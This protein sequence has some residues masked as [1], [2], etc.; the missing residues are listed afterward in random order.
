MKTVLIISYYWPPAGGPGVQR[1]LKFARYLHELGWKVVVLTVKDGVYPARDDSLLEEIPSEVKVF[2]SFSPEPEM[3]LKKLA[4]SDP[5]PSPVGVLA[6]KPSS[7]HKRIIHHIRLNYF[8]PDAK[9][10]WRYNSRRIAERLVQLYKPDIVF[11]TSPPPTTHLIAYD[12]KKRFPVRWVADFRDPWSR[13]HYYRGKRSAWAEKWDQRLERKVLRGCDRIVCVSRAFADLLVESYPEKTTIIPNGYDAGDFVSRYR[14]TERFNI[15]YIGGL[16]SN[17]WY[18]SLFKAIVRLLREGRLSAPEVC[19][20][21]AG[22]IAP[23]ILAE[24]RYIFADYPGVLQIKEYVPHKQATAMMQ[25]ADLL[26]LFMEKV[27]RYQGHLPGKLFEYLAALRPVLGC[28]P[29]DGEAAG[30]LRE[31]QAGGVYEQ[32]EK[33]ADFI[34]TVFQAWKKGEP[35]AVKEQDIVRFERKNLTRRLASVFEE[36][37]KH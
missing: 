35:P 28:G 34:M 25:Q 13:I 30:L 1:P 16:N 6:E 8:I 24:L 4:S 9:V 12:I 17:R 33:M 32:P 15:L 27:D 2:K 19:L 29:G 10:M 23:A 3:L 37:L 11:S 7:F 21:L 31:L 18:P 14:K 26:L 20:T 36:T 5:R 22:N